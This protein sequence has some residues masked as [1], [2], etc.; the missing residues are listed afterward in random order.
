MA[1]VLIALHYSRR[2]AW[3]MIRESIQKVKSD[4][5]LGRLP[6]ARLSFVVRAAIAVFET[7]EY[8]EEIIYSDEELGGFT[9]ILKWFTARWSIGSE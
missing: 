3:D 8:D 9:T 7:N 2:M 6:C 4:E 5:D 1:K